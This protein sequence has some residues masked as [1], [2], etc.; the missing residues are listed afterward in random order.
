MYVCRLPE[1]NPG[2]LKDGGKTHRQL[3]KDAV[4]G[5]EENA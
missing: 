2:K 1:K 4:G 3:R 5:E